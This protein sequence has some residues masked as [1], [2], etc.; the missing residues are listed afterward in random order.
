MVLN[1]MVQNG[2]VN[3][4][5]VTQ[6]LLKMIK[7]LNMGLEHTL[8]G[9][10]THLKTRK[11]QENF[12]RLNAILQL[13]IN[14][15]SGKN[16][17]T[18]N[19]ENMEKWNIDRK[20]LIQQLLSGITTEDLTSLVVLRNQ[21]QKPTITPKTKRGQTNTCTTIPETSHTNTNAPNKS[22]NTI[23]IRV[24]PTLPP[25]KPH[26]KQIKDAALIF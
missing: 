8:A 15:I 19:M 22:T 20:S 18:N 26:Q 3:Y 25:L 4:V 7:S 10:W 9:K 2:H 5:M 23:T 24:E 21:I 17:L 14:Y 12:R 11:H 6:F 1:I 16:M 13:I